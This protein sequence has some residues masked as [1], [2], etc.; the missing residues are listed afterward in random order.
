MDD[1][2]LNRNRIDIST[3]SFI[4]SEI[5]LL[6][7]VL[8]K[9]FGLNGNYYRDRDKGYRMY[10]NT[11]ETEK[12]IEIIKPYVIDSMKYKITLRPRND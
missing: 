2:S 3:Y 9:N 12:L 8:D 1:G 7:R 11:K 5:N 6:L 10:F 4:E